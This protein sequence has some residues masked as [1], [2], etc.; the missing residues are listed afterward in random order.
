LLSAK[1]GSLADSFVRRGNERLRFQQL[2]SARAA[3]VADTPRRTETQCGPGV[4]R[5][6]FG[7]GNVQHIRW[8]MEHI[9]WVMEHIRWVMEHIRWV[10]EH[11]RWVMEKI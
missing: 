2:T 1:G 4:E 7:A 3:R 9:R 8:V 6:L 11:I 10:M 5:G